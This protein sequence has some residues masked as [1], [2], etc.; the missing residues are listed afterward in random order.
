[1]GELKR[2][3][4]SGRMAAGKDTIGLEFQK[5]NKSVLIIA[6]ADALRQEVKDSIEEIKNNTFTRKSEMPEELYNLLLEE[7]K[8]DKID[9]YKRTPRIRKILQL[10]GTE[11]RRHQQDDYWVEKTRQFIRSTDGPICVT[12]ARFLNELKMLK[13]ENFYIVKLDISDKEQEKRLLKRD[14]IKQNQSNHRSEQEFELFDNF[15]LTVSNESRL[16]EDTFKE[17]LEKKS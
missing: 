13:E 11:Y 14:G 12:D 17:V 8:E 4:L 5:Y 16:P 9:V 15:D 2:L 3:A 10:Y 6:F 7:S 1:M